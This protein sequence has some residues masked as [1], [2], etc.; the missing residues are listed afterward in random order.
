MV[1]NLN[2]VSVGDMADEFR[3]YVMGVLNTFHAC[4]TQT[5][6]LAAR[7]V[8]ERLRAGGRFLI[9]GT[10]HS[11]MLA[12]EFY[13]RAGGLACVTPVLPS[14]FQLFEHPLKSTEV[15]RLEAYASVVMKLYS[16][17][18]K[19]AILIASNSGRNGMPVELARLSR[20]CGAAVIAFTSSNRAKSELSRHSSGLFLSDYADIVI[21]SCTPPGDAGFAVA[22]IDAHMGAMSTFTGAY[23][24]QLMSILIA[25][26]MAE[27]DEILPVFKSSNIDG[28]DEWNEALFNRYLKV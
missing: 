13:T 24:A 3:E 16:I 23:L 11:H 5:I 10:G 4:S 2:T 25:R 1:G 12:E 18:G 22:G 21:D 7:T 15:E 17:C 26:Y 28:G 27:N 14:E 19:D 8:V 6:D 20:S 9:T